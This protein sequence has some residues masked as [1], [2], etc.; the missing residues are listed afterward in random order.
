MNV[1]EIPFVKTVGI[2]RAPDAIGLELAYHQNVQN[3][4][5]TIHGSAQ[6]TLAETASGDVLQILFPE[7]IKKAIPVLRESTM[8]FKKPAKKKIFA[9]T[10]VS[11]EAKAKFDEQFSKKG[12][13]L[14]LVEVEI[15]DT[16]DIVTSVASFNW[17]VQ[18]I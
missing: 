13:A 11:K 4:L 1:L 7:L 9:F 12:R 3:H 15:K 8:K 10:S 2:D 18:G 17:F 16:D 6:F 5:K 14:I